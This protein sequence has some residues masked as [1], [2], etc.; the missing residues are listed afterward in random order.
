MHTHTYACTHTH[1]HTHQSHIRTIRAMGLK[2]YYFLKR[3]VFKED[4]KELTIVTIALFFASEQTHCA[5]VVFHSERVRVA[6]TQHVAEQ[7]LKWCKL[8]IAL[9]GCYMA[10]AT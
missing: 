7:P 10:G 5:V 6:F 8:L 1:T 9:F 3:K 2:N 4:L